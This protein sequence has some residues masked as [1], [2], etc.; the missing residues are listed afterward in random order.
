MFYINF[1]RRIHIS[2]DDCFSLGIG[3]HLKNSIQGSKG[4]GMKLETVQWTAIKKKEK[5]I[6]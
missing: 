4:S 1:G 2:V 3:G 6:P 5:K